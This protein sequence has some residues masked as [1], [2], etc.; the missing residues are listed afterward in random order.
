MTRRQWIALG[1]LLAVAC[2]PAHGDSGPAPDAKSGPKLDA[3][4]TRATRV[5]TARLLPSRPTL[6][7]VLPGE[8]EGARDAHLAA[9]LGGYVE[10]VLVWNGLRVKAN[11]PLAYV[12]RALHEL[13]LEQAAL[14]L[15]QAELSQKRTDKAGSSLTAARREQA[16]FAVDSAKIQHRLAELQARRAVI[17]APFDGVI[18]QVMIDVGEVLPPGGPVARLVQLDPVTVSVTVSDRDVL[19]LKEGL[20]VRVQS[21]ARSQILDGK[22]ARISPAADLRTRAFTVEIEVPNGSDTLLPGMIARVQ[23]NVSLEADAL[24]LPQDVLVTSRDGNGVFVAEGGVARW[25]PVALGRVVRDQV[26]IT[27]G[28]KPGDE[29]V[30]TGHRELADGDK[31]LVSRAGTCCAGG[32]VKFED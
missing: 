31:V 32:A 11:Q 18:A 27:S 21:D 13:R 10:K 3:I 28:I 5:E 1:A 20:P 17:R 4:K 22:V 15:E 9:P 30:V 29:V 25:R 8:V 23:L 14:Q 6:E 2:T 24:S 26:V 12:D 19:S 16:Q 7:L